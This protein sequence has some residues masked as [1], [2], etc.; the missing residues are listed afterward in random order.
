[1]RIAIVSCWKYRDAWRPFIELMLK[2]WPDRPYNA[3]LITDEYEDSRE[4]IEGIDT[5]PVYLTRGK[6]W[7]QGLAEYAVLADESILLM[8]EDFFLNA[9]V[10]TELVQIALEQLQERGA[11][12]VRL[13]PCPGSNEDYGDPHFGRIK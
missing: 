10:N 12:M 2:F 6:S 4:F 13:Y 9:P 8:Q 5:P 3:T 1:M 7:S 11:A